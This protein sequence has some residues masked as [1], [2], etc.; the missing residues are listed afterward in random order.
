M[1]EPRQ[2]KGYLRGVPFD[3][4]VVKVDSVWATPTVA[5]AFARMRAR[6]DHDGI[7]LVATEGFRTNDEQQKIWNERQTAEA[8]AA[9]G[10]AARPG[11]STH[12]LGDTF[13]IRTGLTTEMYRRGDRTLTYR[14]LVANAQNFGFVRTVPSECWHWRHLDTE[15]KRG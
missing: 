15:E 6:A 2:V 9:L 7:E 14:W 11:W 8:K 10:V 12:Q 5:E 1:A 13:D 4:Y 3:L